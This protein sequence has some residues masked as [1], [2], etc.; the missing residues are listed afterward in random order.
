MRPFIF[1][2]FR[3]AFQFLASL[4][5]EPSSLRKFRRQRE[6]NNISNPAN[7]GASRIP[8]DNRNF[9]LLTVQL[10]LFTAV[11][12]SNSELIV[13]EKARSVKEIGKWRLTRS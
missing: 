6:S 1:T 3:A 11:G 12:M 9:S 2:P 8:R 10:A 5:I 4:K 13:H 7:N